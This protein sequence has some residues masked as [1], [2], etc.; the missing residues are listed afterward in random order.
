MRA[1][2]VRFDALK[3][4]TRTAGPTSCSP[5][6]EKLRER[7]LRLAGEE[8]LGESRYAVRIVPLEGQAD[9]KLTVED[10]TLFAPRLLP[11]SGELSA[12]GFAACTLGGAL[13]ARVRSLFRARRPSLA[14]ALN[15]LGD[16][17]LA[18]INRRAQ[19]RIQVQASRLGLDMAGE[20]RPGDPGMGLAA[21][22]AV[23]ALAGGAQI[24]VR[25]SDHRMLE[26][27]KS[28]T[29]VVGIG[30][31]LPEA[32]WSR[33][34]ECRSRERC[35]WARPRSATTAARSSA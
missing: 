30:H 9:G 35:T 2:I 11:A 32:T 28:M 14:L 22:A 7:A 29:M 27:V 6:A 34:D 3:A 1:E 10:E 21:Q 26:P 23:L 8:G 5:T 15:A 18:G 33:C 12:L 13:E 25:L 31:N 19:D 17:M 16:E 4:V 20:L 24:G